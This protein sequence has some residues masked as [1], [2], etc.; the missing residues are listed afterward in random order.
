[1]VTGRSIRT[2]V[3]FERGIRTGAS[4]H[5]RKRRPAQP[6]HGKEHVR[7]VAPRPGMYSSDGRRRRR[8]CQREAA[9]ARPCQYRLPAGNTFDEALPN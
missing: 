5:G 8:H 2:E 6:K 7:V 9:E 3:W 1:M 4:L